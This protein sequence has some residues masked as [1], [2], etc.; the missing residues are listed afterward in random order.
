MIVNI[1][2]LRD[3]L[4]QDCYGAYFGGGFGGALME[5][6]DIENAS[7]QELIEIARDKGIDLNAQAG[8]QAVKVKITKKKNKHNGE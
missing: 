1:E 5:S 4:K 6:F 2:K 7:P 8:C 3:E